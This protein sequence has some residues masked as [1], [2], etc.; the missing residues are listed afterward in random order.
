MVVLS[1]FAIEDSSDTTPC[2]QWP[3][4]SGENAMRHGTCNSAAGTFSYDQWTNCDCSGPVG[5][6]KTVY[7]SKC[8]VDVP[9]SLCAQIVDFTACQAAGECD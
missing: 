6:S 1:R 8:V 4:N 3:G 5:T 7:T 9:S 2:K